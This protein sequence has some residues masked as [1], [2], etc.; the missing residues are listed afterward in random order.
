MRHATVNY[1]K[2]F[3]SYRLESGL[4]FF[5]GLKLMHMLIWMA[6]RVKW[7][8]KGPE[9]LRRARAIDVKSVDLSTCDTNLS[10]MTRF[11]MNFTADQVPTR[12]SR[13]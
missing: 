8:G 10:N 12:V 13:V 11:T 7:E 5:V 3:P 2:D 4:T 1:V 9:Y 6:K